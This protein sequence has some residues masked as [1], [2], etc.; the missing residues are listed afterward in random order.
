MIGGSVFELDGSDID[1]A[2]PGALGNNVDEAA[3]REKALK[4]L[5]SAEVKTGE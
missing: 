3:L 4:E 5:Q 2:L 1:N